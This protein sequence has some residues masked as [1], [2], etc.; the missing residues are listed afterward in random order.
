MNYVMRGLKVL[1]MSGRRPRDRHREGRSKVGRKALTGLLLERLEDRTLFS[2]GIAHPDV[3]YR[4]NSGGMVLSAVSGF[5]PAQ[6]RHA[7]GFDQISFSGVQGDGRG[8]TIAIIDPYDDP[9]INS[10]LNVFDSTFGL[11]APPS[12]R[13]VDQTGGTRYP[14]PDYRAAGEISLDVEWA[15]AIAPAANILLVEANA[16]TYDDLLTAVDFARH[17]PGVTTVSMSWGGGEFP[18]E[19]QLDSFFTTPAGHGNVTFVA[20][21]GDLGAP[22]SWPAISPN[23]LSVGGTALTVNPD[24]SWKGETG[25]S[26]SGGGISVNEPQPLY[27]NHFIPGSGYRTSPDVA[28]NADPNTGVAVYNTYTDPYGIYGPGWEA[29]GGTSAGAPQW[30]ALVAIAD[31]GRI[32]AGQLPLDG[33]SQ[34]LP[35]I[36]QLGDTSFHD[37]VVGNNGYSAG[38]GYDLV[39]G[40]GSPVAN[41]VVDGLTSLIVVN[42]PADTIDSDRSV[43]SLREAVLQANA[44]LGP[45]IIS[46]TLPPS[47]TVSLTQGQALK[48]TDAVAITGPGSTKLTVNA[49]NSGGIFNVVGTGAAAISG[50]TLTGGNTSLGGAILD[51]GNLTLNDVAITGNKA[52]N[53]GGIAVSGSG[54][55]TL[56]TSSVTSNSA[57]SGGGIYSAGTVRAI[58]SYFVSNTAT[59]NGG[60]IEDLYGSTT[61]TSCYVVLNTAGGSGG[62]IYTMSGSGLMASL[63]LA[64]CQV[65]D[66]AGLGTGTTPGSGIEF[67]GGGTLTL[68]NNLLMRNWSNSGH[69][70]AGYDLITRGGVIVTGGNNTIGKAA[71]Y[72]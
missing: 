12:F 4:P 23:V 31:Q 14:S 24:Q 67:D 39:T 56:N 20:S 43:T 55:L 36:Y 9:N 48:I 11:A 35:T 10:D 16:L 50:L 53:G 54:T 52:T 71:Y 61:L 59:G 51:G 46:F 33:P 2:L 64:W 1:S 5:T 66:N 62:G 17:Q 47:S 29:V 18:G 7:Y 70:L 32:A 25:W 28:Y 45:D 30:A 21:S 40:R 22:P 58:S 49:N 37:V 60:G 72:N 38:P 8:Q 6:V 63:S 69:T 65:E 41:R 44:H 57:G 27:Q 19:T 13:K 42:T 26:Y 68:N 15:H 3:I 34:T